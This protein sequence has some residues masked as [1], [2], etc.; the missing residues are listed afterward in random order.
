M[1]REN[2]RAEYELAKLYVDRG[3]FH[4]AIHKI[5]KLSDYYFEK[6]D[7]DKFLDCMVD[8]IKM[9]T[10]RD[11]CTKI[12]QLKERLQDLVLRDNFQLTS[13]TYYT[14]GVCEACKS[15][16][17]AAQD[18]FQKSLSI[19][20]K[21]NDKKNMSY[22]IAGLAYTYTHLGKLSEAIQE[23]YNLK[24][25]LEIIPIRDLQI[26]CEI[27]N[28]AILR[29]MGQT[30]QALDILWK[31]Y[32]ILRIE[33]NH[34]MSMQLLYNIGITYQARGDLQNARLYLQLL[35]KTLDTKNFIRLN[36]DVERKLLE[37]G[38]SDKEEYDLVFDSSGSIVTEKKRGKID[39]NNQ[40]ILMDL[41][42]LFVK[43]PGQI[44]S[45][46][47]IVKRIWNESYSPSIHD[48]KIYVTIKR[49]RSLIEPDMNNPKYIFRSKN[50]YYLNK[51]SKI[52]LQ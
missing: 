12:I 15:N 8:L 51:E 4:I 2:I 40:F 17:S 39:F 1:D 38:C 32:E 16:F 47:D 28:G 14:L 49:L 3:D 41:L 20:L 26:S 25:F 9:Y 30:D 24:V 36:R 31:C 44:F 23:L 18:Y 22:A 45:K 33:K 27:F 7:F 21:D 52:R 19:A 37:L 29:K 34:Y 35:R 43:Y 6:K 48:N 50:G 10:E 11:E 5:E 42:Q 46:E 13:F